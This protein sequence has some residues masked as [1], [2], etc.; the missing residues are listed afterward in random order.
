MLA[1]IGFIGLGLAA[2][3][4]YLPTSQ[5]SRFAL[6]R[7]GGFLPN[8]MGAVLGALTNMFSFMGTE[9]V[10]IAAAESKYPGKQISKATNSVSLAD[11]FVYSC[12]SSASW[13][14]VPWNDPMLRTSVLPDRLERMASRTRK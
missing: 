9:I 4:G 10:T 3:F 1:I 12:R 8:G 6:V 5:V 7:S 11:R 13:R 2:I 14:M